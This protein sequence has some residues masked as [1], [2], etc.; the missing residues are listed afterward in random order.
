MPKNTKESRNPVKD[1][2]KSIGIEGKYAVYV[3]NGVFIILGYLI[4]GIIK[5][6]LTV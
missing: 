5:E 1:I 3:Q 2:L 4:I 6:G